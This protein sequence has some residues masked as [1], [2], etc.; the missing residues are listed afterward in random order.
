M[1]REF[2]VVQ[3]S[4]YSRASVKTKLAMVL[5]SHTDT[6]KHLIIN[7][8]QVSRARRFFQVVMQYY[9]CIA[10]MC[11]RKVNLT[12]SLTAFIVV[13]RCLGGGRRLGGR[14]AM[15]Y[16]DTQI[17]AKLA[18]VVAYTLGRFC[19]VLANKPA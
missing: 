4:T 15:A 1:P 6:S 18:A 11:F 16:S 9:A 5:T 10:R 13:L 17:L 19:Y 2:S 8:L 7:S 12:R 3:Y 14:G